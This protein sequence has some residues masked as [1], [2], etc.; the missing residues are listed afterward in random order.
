M[1]CS[2]QRTAQMKAVLLNSQAQNTK[3][4]EEHRDLSEK[5]GLM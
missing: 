2:A 5:L 4:Q 1:P 3:L